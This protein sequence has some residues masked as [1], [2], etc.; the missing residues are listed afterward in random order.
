M[1]LQDAIGNPPERLCAEILATRRL[2]GDLQAG[3]LLASSLLDHGPGG[4]GF[5]LA[6]SNHALDQ[7]ELG[8]RPI[9]LSAFEGITNSL[10]DDPLALAHR[11]RGHMDACMIQ[12]FHRRHEPDPFGA[13]EQ[14]R[15]RYAAILEGHICRVRAAKPHLLV[16][17]RHRYAGC[18]SLDEKGRN[19]FPS[20]RFGSRARKHREDARVRRVGREALAA[21]DDIAV[22]VAHGFRFDRRH[23]RA[24]ARLG[25]TERCDEVSSGDGRQIFLALL[26][27][28]VDQDAQGTYTIAGAE[29][30]AK[31]HRGIGDFEDHAG[32]LVHRQ[33]EPAVALGDGHA[34]ETEILE[35]RNYSRRNLVFLLDLRFC[36][37]ELLARKS[38]HDLRKLL[39]RLVTA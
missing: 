20:L 11:H 9:E 3:V 12:R 14:R 8:D 29:V 25:Q 6:I 7:L 33:T 27:G 34:E 18:S 5:R 32:L 28:A 1:D 13:S 10:V 38:P 31:H 16:M 17:R 30:G 24:G 2:L 35:L 36:W 22:A 37:N 19:A 39:D 23:V 15:V 4:I 21:V 26:L